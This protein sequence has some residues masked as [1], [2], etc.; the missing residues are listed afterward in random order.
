MIPEFRSNAQETGSGPTLDS[1]GGLRIARWVAA[2]SAVLLLVMRCLYARSYRWNS[3]EPQHLHVVWAWA[4]G[5]LPY[6]DVFDNHTPLFH[7]LSV[8][9]FLALGERPDIVVV[10]RLAMIPLFGLTLWLVYRIGAN[11]FSRRAGLW[12]AVFL[13][14]LPNYFFVMGQ[15][16]TDVLWTVLWLAFLA[17]VTGGPL[18]NVRLFLA[19]I[20][21]GAAFGV[22]MKTTLLLLVVL[23]SGA[24]TW[25]TLRFWEPRQGE[26]RPTRATAGL[27]A[28]VAIGGLLLIPLLLIGYFAM[29]GSLGPMYYCVIEHNT[30]PGEH[31]PMRLLK[32]LASYGWLTLIPALGLIAGLRPLFATDARRAARQVFLILSAGFFYPVLHVLW[33]MITQQDY[34]PWL[35]LL[36]LVVTPQVM[37]VEKWIGRWGTRLVATLFLLLF[38]FELQEVLREAP[39]LGAGNVHQISAIA[40]TLR[41]TDRGEYAMDLKGDL[42]FRPRPYYYALE[43]LTRERLAAGLLKDEISERLVETRTAVVKTGSKGMTERALTFIRANYIPVGHVSVLGKRL[44]PAEDGLIAFEVSIPERYTVVTKRGTIIGTLDGQVLDGGRWLDRGRHELRLASPQSGADAFLIWTRALE[45]GF[46]PFSTVSG[47]GGVGESRSQRPS[48]GDPLSE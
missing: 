40:E 14:F 36:V 41:L 17:V 27:S 15:Y 21:M 19:G 16:R 44:P 18:T 7:I 33:R 42:I 25:I 32:R 29:R 12:S 47:E 23:A 30:L 31:T 26:L 35:P 5:L 34:I 20:L 22:S 3:D 39:L 6:R 43:T 46:S 1:E 48:K 9:L 10:M 11:V 24:G 8:P 13:G 4:N 37:L 45:R 28:A 2:A 38:S